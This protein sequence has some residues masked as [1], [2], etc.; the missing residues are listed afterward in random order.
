ML[1]ELATVISLIATMIAVIFPIVLYRKMA[2]YDLLAAKAN[3]LLDITED[4]E[5]NV[6][7]PKALEVIGKAVGQ[8]VS[9]SLKMSFL[10]QSS[11]DARL[12]KGMFKA[13]ANDM[14]DEHLPWL[15]MVQPILGDAMNV[16]KFINK[17]PKGAIRMIQQFGPM[18][19]DW[20]EQR[21]SPGQNKSTRGSRFRS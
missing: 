7:Y 5:G 4:E 10:D 18:V 1:N 20:M 16:R 13:V 12:D 19:K 9:T 6:H 3:A 8:G 11:G 15:D 14:L 21:K 17:N 2:K